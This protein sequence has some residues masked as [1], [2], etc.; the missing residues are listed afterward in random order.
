MSTQLIEVSNI[1]DV[2]IN[3][4]KRALEIKEGLLND[5]ESFTAVSSSFEAEC[6]GEA[7]KSLHEFIKNVGK[8]HSEVKAP[9]LSVGRKIDALKKDLIEEAEA[10]KKRLGLLLGDYQAEERRKKREAEEEARKLAQQKIL[11]AQEQKEA[12]ESDFTKSEEEIQ[13]EQERIN[14]QTRE[15]VQQTALTASG[16]AFPVKGIKAREKMRWKIT[17]PERLVQCRPDLF[18]PPKGDD[19]EIKAPLKTK[20]NAALSISPTLPGVE[21]WIERKATL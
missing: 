18:V 6:C 8:A 2:S 11:E 12:L 15:A 17:D 1:G 21:T 19:T 4:T 13:A 10:E 16:K 7:M 20:I 14:Q 3:A 5:A 9:V